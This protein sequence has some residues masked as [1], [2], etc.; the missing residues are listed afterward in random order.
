MECPSCHE[1]IADGANFCP[2]CGQRTGAD[3][4]GR[5][6]D[7]E[8]TLPVGGAHGPPEPPEELRTCPRCGAS[9]GPR[10][11]LCGRCGADL[12]TGD[13]GVL[14]PTWDDDVAAESPPRPSSDRT[15]IVVAVLAVGAIIGLLVGGVLLLGLRPGS[16]NGPDFDPGVYPEQPGPLVVAGVTPTS[17]HP[18]D[19][20]VRYDAGNLVDGDPTTAWAPEEASTG[21]GF[22]LRLSEPA[23]V[24]GLTLDLPAEPVDP[25][26]PTEL[27]VTLADGARFLVAFQ[28]RSGIQA[29]DFPE[30][31]LTRRLEIEVVDLGS[32]T[33]P[34]AIA[35][36]EVLGWE[37]RGEDREAV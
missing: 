34:L 17:V 25:R 3:A 14:T 29:V 27:L 26:R 28:E 15:S 22:A 2:F 24:D 6:T 31:V 11:V 35:G 36:I 5:A 4:A 9:N 10:R 12:D 7:V 23:W 33:G 21:E 19:G 32:G 30:P 20:D 1:T 37:A 8:A 13:R 18:P 16:G